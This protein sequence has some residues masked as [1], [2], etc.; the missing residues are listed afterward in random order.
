MFHSQKPLPPRQL[1][2]GAIRTLLIT[3]TWK[4]Q[5]TADGSFLFYLHT[6]CRAV[7]LNYLAS[8]HDMGTVA[9]LRECARLKIEIDEEITIFM[10]RFLP[11]A[12]CLNITHE[13]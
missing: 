6:P 3:K 12:R 13:L 8:S 5:H 10:A 7:K 9:Q 4:K 2:S 1:L 11:A